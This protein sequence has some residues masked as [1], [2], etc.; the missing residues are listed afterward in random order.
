MEKSKKN[1]IYEIFNSASHGLGVVLGIIFLVLMIA[2]Y[3]NRVTGGMLLGFIV[4]GIC[5]ILM[6]LAS[7][8]YHGI[9]NPK[10]KSILRIFDHSSIFLFI[11]GSY[12]PIVLYVLSGRMRILFLA[13]IWIIAVFGTIFKILTYKKYDRFI[14]LSVIIYI[15]MGWLAIFLIKPIIENTSRLFIIFIVTGGLLYTVGTYFYKKRTPLYNHLIWHVFVLA[16]AVCQYIG[17]SN[18][19]V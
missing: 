11:A 3:A 2:K 4:Y 12:T 6:F 8:L 14:K 1:I 16:A 7:T 19:L 5:F 10:V 13:G 9:Q 17:I 15:A 18:F